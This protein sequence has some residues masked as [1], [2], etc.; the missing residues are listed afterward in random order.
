MAFT[1]ATAVTALHAAAP[2]DALLARVGSHVAGL[3]EQ[4][5]VVIC[6]E[7][8]RQEASN[9][10]QRVGR[11]I[12]AEILFVWIPDERSWLTVRN[13]RDVNNVA[14]PE[15]A[16]RIEAILSD[17]GTD[18]VTRLLKLQREGARYDIGGVERTTSNPMMAL[19]YLAPG[20]QNH[21][22]FTDRGQ[23]QIGRAPAR[24]IAFTERKPLGVILFNETPVAVSGEFFARDDASGVAVARTVLRV[25]KPGNAIITVD[26][27]PN[28]KVGAWVP[29][30]MQERYRDGTICYSDY[31]NYRR[32]ETAGRLVP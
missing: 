16:N 7:K 15:S 22:Q 30:H 10:R 24:K 3:R 25:A 32:F 21:F 8:Y 31:S 19:Q 18:V 20:I 5:N 23:E 1:L 13:I 9:V 14:M 26:F 6:D 29:V 27:E 28:A 12:H 4:L 2:L 11:L 17:P